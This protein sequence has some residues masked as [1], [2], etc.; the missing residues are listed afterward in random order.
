[1]SNNYSNK[2][3]TTEDWIHITEKENGEMAECRPQEQR[4]WSPDFNDKQ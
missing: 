2:D 1:M 3:V 4:E